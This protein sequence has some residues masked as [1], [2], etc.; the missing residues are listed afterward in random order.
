MYF[1]FYNHLIDTRRI[2]MA[3][4]GVIALEELEN[5]GGYGDGDVTTPINDGDVH[6]IC[7]TMD[8][9]ELT[10]DDLVS[11]TDIMTIVSE[12]GVGNVPEIAQMAIE[13]FHYRLFDQHRSG[14]SVASESRAKIA[15]EEKNI[16]GRIWDGIIKIIGK[17]FAFIKKAIGKRVGN[18][19]QY[20][21]LAKTLRQ[22]D[23]KKVARS[24]RDLREGDKKAETLLQSV[25][26]PIL[27]GWDHK[28]SKL[29]YPLDMAKGIITL[30]FVKSID[31]MDKLSEESSK[32]VKRIEDLFKSNSYAE[33]K[34]IMEVIADNIRKSDVIYKNRFT[35]LPDSNY[36]SYDADKMRPSIVKSPHGNQ[37]VR[38]TINFV[39]AQ[40]VLVEMID[41][42]DV[43]LNAIDQLLEILPKYDFIGK[44]TEELEANAKNMK[45]IYTKMME[46]NDR[47]NRDNKKKIISF[48]VNN[49]NTTLAMLQVT[50]REMDLIN[51]FTGEC[52]V[53]IHRA[54]MFDKE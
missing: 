11:H 39:E 41:N 2:D 4:L 5:S 1:F 34:D 54:V 50:V 18:A 9:V 44:M 19:K 22:M 42:K 3:R 43:F 45:E 12:D 23:N 38:D 16:F 37:D 47:I 14:V 25:S 20:Q 29:V 31:E 35:P 52:T 17:L 32:Y 21:T 48:M 27:Y 24:I 28:N 6:E 40:R 30:D 26:K 49:F 15:L 36:L 7:N 8:G 53:L 33:A 13:S 46:G 51:R 10:L